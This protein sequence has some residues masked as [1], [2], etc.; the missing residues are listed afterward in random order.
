MW[1]FPQKLWFK[2]PSQ[3]LIEDAMPILQIVLRHVGSLR[4]WRCLS[5][6]CLCQLPLCRALPRVLEHLHLDTSRRHLTSP[7]L[8][9][10]IC[11]MD[12]KNQTRLTQTPALL[13]S[14][15]AAVSAPT[16]ESLFPLPQN[17]ENHHDVLFTFVSAQ[18]PSSL[19]LET[20][21]LPSFGV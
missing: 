4:Q 10:P 18:Y 19:V 11:K 9:F 16:S 1:V 20:S 8:T 7:C 14:R 3:V 12:E 21:S 2:S 6:D 15:G 17:G 13:L 5:Q